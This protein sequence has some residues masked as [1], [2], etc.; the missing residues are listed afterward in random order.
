[1]SKVTFIRHAR[2]VSPYNDYGS[3]SF[4]DISDLATGKIDPD[5]DPVMLSEVK[6]TLI[7]LK[8]VTERVIILHAD[9][10]RAFQTSEY[11]QKIARE[12][13]GELPEIIQT[14]ELNE[15][16]FDPKKL[17]TSEEFMKDGLGCIR[18][19]VFDSLAGEKILGGELKNK[20]S[21]ESVK[22]IFS[23]IEKL[24]RKI[25][26]LTSDGTQVICVTH[27]FL[28][29]LLQIYFLL[30]EKQPSFVTK[31]HLYEM[32]NF[33]YGQGFLME[34]IIGK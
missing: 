21:V 10:Q 19:R 27:G 6:K 24:E 1:M 5:V 4:T 2:L 25:S 16:F 33:E 8:S 14:P 34:Y 31:K 7:R 30:E 11:I 22:N 26:A 23:R 29:R 9:S 32:H 15:I 3:L 13:I 18:E 20:K 28:L 12:E 17:M